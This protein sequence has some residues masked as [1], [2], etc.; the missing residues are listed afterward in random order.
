MVFCRCC[1]KEIHETALTC[2]HCGG[3]QNLSSQKVGDGVLWVPLTSLILSILC[4]SSLLTE[5]EYEADVYLGGIAIALSSIVMGIISL[6]NQKRE[7][8]MAITA[9]VL[10]SIA[11]L[12]FFA[13]LTE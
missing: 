5:T 6:K 3:S 4:F 2:P 10:S 7:K 12:T 8:A 11:V 13:L 1:G 9:I